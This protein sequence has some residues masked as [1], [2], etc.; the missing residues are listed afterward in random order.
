MS[1]T[2]ESLSTP[3]SDVLHMSNFPNEKEC[4]QEKNN[5]SKETGLPLYLFPNKVL[6]QA[7]R[8]GSATHVD[9]IQIH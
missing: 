2:L 4:N 5:Q 9:I 7:E 8:K 1:Y 6:K 3:I